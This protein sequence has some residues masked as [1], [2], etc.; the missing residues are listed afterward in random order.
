MEKLPLLAE[1]YVSLGELFEDYE[2]TLRKPWKRIMELLRDFDVLSPEQRRALSYSKADLDRCQREAQISYDVTLDSL[3]GHYGTQIEEFLV[4]WVADCLMEYK[5]L[6]RAGVRPGVSGGFDQAQGRGEFEQVVCVSVFLLSFT[7]S[8]IVLAKLDL[9]F[10]SLEASG[11]D[12]KQLTVEVEAIKA[13]LAKMKKYT[14]DEEKREGK[15][16]L[17]EVAAFLCSEKACLFPNV[18]MLKETTPALVNARVSFYCLIFSKASLKHV[19]VEAV[20]RKQFGNVRNK[21]A[22]VLRERAVAFT[23]QNFPTYLPKRENKNMHAEEARSFADKVSKSPNVMLAFR[24]AGQKDLKEALEDAAA[25][26]ILFHQLKLG[27]ATQTAMNA[28]NKKNEN[29]FPS[30]IN[31]SSHAILAFGIVAVCFVCFLFF[32]F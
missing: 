20:T 11:K 19:D 22:E 32:A 7:K 30:N 6:P 26:E 18:R 29:K 2:K 1:G 15:T 16:C 8:Q 14:S 5:W 13:G 31:W 10:K 9:L 17:E 4:T 21:I 3:L 24:R 27:E 12:I 25:A 28:A 23:S